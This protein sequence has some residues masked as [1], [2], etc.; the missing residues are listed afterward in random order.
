M[1]FIKDL[2]LK[3]MIR[4]LWIFFKFKINILLGIEIVFIEIDI[5]ILKVMVLSEINI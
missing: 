4:I 1:K 3:F 2:L 5:K